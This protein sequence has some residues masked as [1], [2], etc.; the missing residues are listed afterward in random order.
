[1]STNDRRASNTSQ[2]QDTHS[3]RRLQALGFRFLRCRVDKSP[4]PGWGPNSTTDDVDRLGECY[5]VVPPL[6]YVILDFDLKPG[7]DGLAAFSAAFDVPPTTWTVR[8]PSGGA[9]MYYRYPVERGEVGQHPPVPGVDVRGQHGYVLGP[10]SP[11]YLLLDEDDAEIADAPDWLLDALRFAARP[12]AASARVPDTFQPLRVVAPDTL[13]AQTWADVEHAL[14]YVPSDD[15]DV[16]VRVGLALAMTAPSER[17]AAT[18]LAWSARSPKFEEG[19]ARKKWREL[20]RSARGDLTHRTVFGLAMA[21]GWPNDRGHEVEE[22]KAPAVP[23]P[24]VVEALAEPAGARDPF[25]WADLDPLLVG[26]LGDM[27]EWI[28]DCNTRS[29]R[30]AAFGAAIAALG[31]ALA[32]R[33]YARVWPGG[34]LLVA[35]QVPVIVVA[36]TGA[37]KDAPLRAARAVTEFAGHTCLGDLAHHQNT[38]YSE[39]VRGDGALGLVLDE[40]DAALATLNTKTEAGAGKEAFLKTLLTASAHKVYGPSVSPRNPHREE[41][42]REFGAGAWTGGIERPAVVL[43]GA[44]TGSIW[45]RIA[46]NV[47]GGLVGRLLVLDAAGDLEPPKP[48]TALTSVVPATIEYWVRSVAPGRMEGPFEI[49]PPVDPRV[50][51]FSREARAEV[52]RVGLAFTAESN[53]AARELGQDRADLFA[54]GVEHVIRLAVI[55]ALGAAIDPTRAD[56]PEVRHVRAAEAL[57]RW[58]IGRAAGHTEQRQEAS[59][60]SKAIRVYRDRLAR[61][62]AILSAKERAAGLTETPWHYRAR[63]VR[64]YEAHSHVALQAM[65][66]SGEVVEDGRR[67]AL[68]S[69]VP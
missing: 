31:G 63:I 30:I 27:V 7:K 65:L 18:W 50:V 64:G 40:A 66:A 43:F 25:P 46:G 35:P 56:G 60:V 67:L 37:G 44:S 11:G 61:P 4:E 17:A 62:G 52:D 36:R 26:P 45:D 33:L 38:L 1:M 12:A 19:A 28:E 34:G 29:L 3:A 5:G 53:A 9:H 58:A 16:W 15:Y 57:V 8:T 51:E 54:R 13:D 47:A 14:E 32:R 24:G 69:R 49:G 2:M 42:E 22:V 68:A 10:G 48:T 23:D 21:A 39:L 59:P 41:I 6:G 55:L 20:A